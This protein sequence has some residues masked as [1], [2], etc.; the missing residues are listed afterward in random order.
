MSDFD[1]II[2]T[3]PGMKPGDFDMGV[4]GPQTPPMTPPR[5]TEAEEMARKRAEFARKEFYKNR[6]ILIEDVPP[7]TYEEVKEFMGGYKIANINISRK[8]RN[9]YVILKHGEEAEEIVDVL[10]GKKLLDKE[11]LVSIKPN[12]TLL[13]LAHLPF[14]LTDHDLRKFACQFGIIEKCFL[15]RNEMSGESKGYGLVEYTHNRD[16]TNTARLKID[17]ME[18]YQCRVHCEFIQSHLT[19]FNDL[20]SKCLFINKLPADFVNEQQL[21]ELCRYEVEV[22]FSKIGMKNDQPLGFAIVEF[23]TSEDA[24]MMQARLHGRPVRENRT[25]SATFCV[26]GMSGPELYNKALN[27]VGT[28]RSAGSDVKALGLI[29]TPNMPPPFANRN[30]N[31]MNPGIRLGMR[32]PP[33]PQVAQGLRNL[34]QQ[35][36]VMQQNMNQ[37][38]QGGPRPPNPAQ[39]QPSPM[40]MGFLGPGPNMLPAA[41]PMMQQAITLLAASLQSQQQQQQLMMGLNG[42]QMLIQQQN[43]MGPN[44]LPPAQ[45]ALLGNPI[46]LQTNNFLQALVSQLQRQQ[47]AS[48]Q[49]PQEQHPPPVNRPNNQENRQQG[50]NQGPGMMPPNHQM[51]G[52][53]PSSNMMQPP[54]APQGPQGQRQNSQPP[55]QFQAQNQ[56][57]LNNLQQ[58]FMNLQK[59]GVGGNSGPNQMQQQPRQTQL[60]QQNQPRPNNIPQNQGQALL[61]TIL[62][63]VM[64]SIMNLGNKGQNQEGPRDMDHRRHSPEQRGRERERCHSER[65]YH[66]RGAPLSSMRPRHASTSRVGEIEDGAIQRLYGNNEGDHGSRQG[67]QDP[68]SQ[69][70]L[71]G[72]VGYQHLDG[73]HVGERRERPPERELRQGDDGQLAITINQEAT[74]S[75]GQGDGFSQSYVYTT[76]KSAV[77]DGDVDQQFPSTSSSGQPPQEG[78][79]GHF[80]PNYYV[81]NDYN[82]YMTQLQVPHQTPSASSSS[83]SSPTGQGGPPSQE[84]VGQP[85]QVQQPVGARKSKTMVE[86]SHASGSSS[87]TTAPVGQKGPD[88]VMQ[89]V[90]QIV[91]QS[92]SG[93][94]LQN[95]SASAAGS[96]TPVNPLKRPATCLV[97]GPEPSPEGEYVGQHSQG[98]GGH[99]SASYVKRKRLL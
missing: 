17:G 57:A 39:P 34:F 52:P 12:E 30:T 77:P 38:M 44:R 22:I 23:T 99:Y 54:P 26:P 45:Q 40:G 41:N 76:E 73:G 35:L 78:Q 46:M 47:Q 50:P 37:L 15:M 55:P 19:A 65:S 83:Q 87:D 98:L 1:V 51:R 85:Q 8:T 72:R 36:Q 71:Q 56:N 80:D 69:P 5:L 88:G 48:T 6:K 53:I 27:A 4:P 91:A 9:A 7:V 24:E 28:G 82:N 25:M 75:K 43:N 62:S 13:C 86:R 89:A 79:Q 14:H 81:Y 90:Q 68:V 84:W 93:G 18:V 33:P 63:S 32:P 16:H 11:V 61:Q 10:R 2:K 49:P 60:N 31:N 29:P 20:H 21:D 97:P 42:L 64:N 74:T 66:N 59:G 94:M 96:S 70:P 95:Q 92:L 58:L 67:C 3:E